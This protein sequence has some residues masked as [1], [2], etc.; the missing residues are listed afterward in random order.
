MECKGI[1][2]KIQRNAVHDG[3][4]TRTS[5]FLKGCS[6]QCAWCCNPESQKLEPE[7][8]VYPSQCTGVDQ[9][10]QCLSACPLDAD[11]LFIRNDAGQI[12]AINRELCIN[13]YGCTEQCPTDA[14]TII[15]QEMTVAQVM[16]EILKD[17]DLFKETNG[18]V[19]I[20]GGDPFMQPKFTLELLKACKKAKIHTGVESSLCVNW[21]DVEKALD[22]VDFFITD[23]KSMDPEQHLAQT[24]GNFELAHENIGKLARAYRDTYIRIPLIPGFNDS[25][26]NISKS[27]VFIDE[28]FGINLLK[29]Q[30]LQYYEQ[31]KDKYAALNRDFPLADLQLPD[32]QTYA[33]SVEQALS[34][35]KEQGLPSQTDR[36][37]SACD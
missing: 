30:V 11:T 31:G 13:C 24:G 14:L 23:I 17:K 6:L 18:G 3:P 5:V 22:F 21:E 36:Q 35:I 16:E 1:V 8:A 9:C 15:G 29:V 33:A 26:D 25:P 10:G 32:A 7:I 28:E 19:T 27:S 4:G 20:G 2:Y 34:I 37:I 12:S